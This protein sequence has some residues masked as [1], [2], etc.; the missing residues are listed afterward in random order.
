MDVS[1]LVPTQGSSRPA[2]SA[3]TTA[4][5]KPEAASLPPKAM[6]AA[7]AAGAETPRPAAPTTSVSDRIERSPELERR[8]AELRAELHRQ[9]SAVRERAGEISQAIRDANEASQE[10]LVR[11]ALGIIHGEL[12]FVT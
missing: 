11:A 2:E 12:F 1:N 3:T 4:R 7:A 8:V 5:S 9:D 6:A 10:T